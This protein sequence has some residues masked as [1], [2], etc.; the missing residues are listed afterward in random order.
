MG[1]VVKVLSTFFGGGDVEVLR[2][3]YR[4]SEEKWR[5]GWR[6]KERFG[7]EREKS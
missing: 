2:N 4:I 3:F 5:K 7:D 6:I 1:E